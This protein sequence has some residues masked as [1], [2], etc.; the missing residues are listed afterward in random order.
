[1]WGGVGRRGGVGTL[2][3]W[4]A[5]LATYTHQSHTE[6]QRGKKGQPF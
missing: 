3:P 6:H 2:A 4:I 1:M 5:S